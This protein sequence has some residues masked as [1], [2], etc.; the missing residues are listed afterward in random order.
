MSCK[1]GA[2]Q[3]LVLA[4]PDSSRE[5]KGRLF[6]NILITQLNTSVGCGCRQSKELC[7]KLENIPIKNGSNSVDSWKCMVF[8]CFVYSWLWFFFSTITTLFQWSKKITWPSWSCM[9]KKSVISFWFLLQKT[10]FYLSQ[11]AFI[12]AVVEPKKLQEIVI[13]VISLHALFL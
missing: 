13:F 9:S 6:T 1:L 8:F 5:N 4:Y 2:R 11:T 7:W 12:W 3:C 10:C